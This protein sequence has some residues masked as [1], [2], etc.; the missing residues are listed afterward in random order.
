M[1][2]FVETDEDVVLLKASE[3]RYRKAFRIIAKAAVE[4]TD[5]GDFCDRILSDLVD[6]LDYDLGVIRLYDESHKMHRMEAR[7]LDK[8][9]GILQ[10]PCKAHQLTPHLEGKLLRIH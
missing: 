7:S 9:H 5:P 8:S 10:S 6:L 3:E 2:P 1:S 4:S